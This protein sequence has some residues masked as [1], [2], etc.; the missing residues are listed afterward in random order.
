MAFDKWRNGIPVA[1][2]VISSAKEKDLLPVLQNLRE[3]LKTADS[4]WEP[5]S[6]I[7]DNTQAEINALR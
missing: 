5:T 3:K 4:S 2:F 1:F 7:V 6:F